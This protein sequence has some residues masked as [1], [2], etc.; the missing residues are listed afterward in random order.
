MAGCT[1]RPSSVAARD[2][3]DPAF[4]RIL[5]VALIANFVMFGVEWTASHFGD[6]MSLLADAL[7]FLGDAAN[8]GISLLVV[9]MAITAR[10]RASLVKSLT[11]GAFGVWV[12]GSAIHRAIAGSAPDAAVMGGVALVALA[13][14]VAVAIL[15]YRHRNGDSN[16]QS[17]WLCSRND[18]IGNVAVIVA[19]TGVFASGSRWPDLVVAAIIAALS[20][21]AAVRVARLAMQELRS[22][23]HRSEL[24]PVVHRDF[25]LS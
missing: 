10:A 18:A 9:G 12:I 13:V 24:H 20:V 16:R 23:P 21:G 6:S 25:R 19:A 2:G 3:A 5:W 17:V 22:A 8:Y 15:L 4:R 1:D 14:N 11:M 7:D